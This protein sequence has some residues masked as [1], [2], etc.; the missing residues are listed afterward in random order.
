MT[1]MHTIAALPPMIDRYLEWWIAGTIIIVGLLV[2]G[3]RDVAVFSL[4]RVW[5]ISS[6]CF[7][8]SIRKRVLWIT[9][10]AI[11]GIVLVS[12][13]QR[14]ID[15]ADAVR[16]M[17]KVSLFA[18]GL[19]VTI[20]A[21]ILACTNL[22]KEIENRVIFT[23]V[24]KPTTRLE[25][26]AGKVLGFAR[27]SAA[28]LIIMGLFTFGFLYFNS[29]SLQRGITE[30]LQTMDAS[31]A[32]RPTLEYY[33]DNGLLTARGLASPVSLQVLAREA[34]DDSE[35]WF[36]GGEGDVLVPFDIPAELLVPPG[37]ASAPPLSAGLAIIVN[38]GFDGRV[39]PRRGL[40]DSTLPPTIAAPQPARGNT[41]SEAKVDVSLLDSMQTTIVASTA[42]TAAQSSLTDPT[43]QEPGQWF[44]PP[45]AA[46]NIENMRQFYVAIVGLN[47]GVE[48]SLK[49]GSV[50]LLVPPATPNAQPRIIEPAAPL[51]RWVF[52]GRYGRT[53]FQVRGG[54]AQKSPTHVGTFSF[55]DA[56][57]PSSSGMIPFEFRADIERSGSDDADEAPT[58]LS[59][60]VRNNQSG[61]QS[62]PITTLIESNRPIF[63][64]VPGEFLASGD[65]DVFVR[66]VTQGHYI[67]VSRASLS[68]VR[69]SESFVFNLS[70]SLLVMWLMAILVISTAIFASTF[71]SW[72]IAIVLTLVMLLG[73]WGVVQLGDALQPGIGNQVATDLGFQRP[74]VT[75]TASKVVEA[76]AKFLTVSAK[77]LPDISQF[78]SIE[79]LERGVAVPAVKVRDSLLVL[80]TFAVPLSVLSYVILRN[81]EVAP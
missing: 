36:L 27:V 50:K 18:T 69:S 3:L 37:D 54:D 34:V 67:S 56:A 19:I 77:V 21:V 65:Y 61:R 16:Q 51:S 17:L 73:R 63:F 24:T 5:A 58:K 79:D 62:E 25:I 15:E 45:Q 49:S 76:L 43:G 6:V 26:V 10:L 70:K 35:R 41:V 39:A 52:R 8:E 48:M 30:R 9:P 68:V 64:K 47:D 13:F 20:T 7:A 23:I 44:L 60:V 12:Q 29:F 74:E 59:V 55:R 32:S 46:P 11:I 40:P 72:P 57:P 38:T 42:L 66:C 33:R 53:G 1:V 4:S 2:Y 75:V 81:K 78:A 28:I 31:S 14:P 71:L 22:P 80:L